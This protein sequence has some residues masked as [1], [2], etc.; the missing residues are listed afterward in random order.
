[1][2]PGGRTDAPAIYLSHGVPPLF[3]DSAWMDQLS[4]WAQTLPKPRAILVVSAYWESAPLMVSSLGSAKPQVYDFH[5][6][7]GSEC[8]VW[9]VG[10]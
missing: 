1:M 6:C 7:V 4:G 10:Q 2:E 5:G 8:R 9:I 3:D